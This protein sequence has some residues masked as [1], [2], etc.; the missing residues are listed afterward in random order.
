MAKITKFKSIKEI[1][2]KF[3]EIENT[4]YEEY[5]RLVFFFDGSEISEIDEDSKEFLSPEGHS[6]DFDSFERN[7]DEVNLIRLEEIE[8]PT[9]F[10]EFFKLMK[11][12]EVCVEDNIPKYLIELNESSYILTFDSF[13]ENITDMTELIEKYNNIKIYKTKQ[14]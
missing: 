13:N 14:I 5:T 3:N 7:L 9:D 12:C 1:I 2:E 6:F 11:K 4:E 10:K 8:V